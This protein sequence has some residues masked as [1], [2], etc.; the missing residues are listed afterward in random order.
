MIL[1]KDAPNMELLI[2]NHEF[3]MLNAVAPD[4]SIDDTPRKDAYLW[5]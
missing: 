3:M 2:G 5:L 4:G 1:I